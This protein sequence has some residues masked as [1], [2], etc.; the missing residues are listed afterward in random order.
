MSGTELCKLL[1]KKI[2][3]DVIIYALTAQVLP[4][5]RELFLSE[6][7]DGLLMKPFKEQDLLTVFNQKTID[8]GPQDI[9]IDISKVE[10]MTFGDKDQLAKILAQFTEDCLN[11]IYELKSDIENQDREKM[12]LLV[13]RIAG[14]TAQIGASAL[15]KEFRMAEI[16]LQDSKEISNKQAGDILLITDELQRLIKQ[17]KARY[18]TDEVV[19]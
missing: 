13:H 14:R 2:P 18:L 3:D 19:M 10:K 16:D 5:E 17:I 1:R 9:E 4:D 8:A 6:C 11:D 7:F 15:A 12:T